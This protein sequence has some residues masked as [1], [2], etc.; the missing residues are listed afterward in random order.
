MVTMTN[1]DDPI[2]FDG[3]L[4]AFD[5]SDSIAVNLK[6]PHDA[7]RDTRVEQPS[8]SELVLLDPEGNQTSYKVSDYSIV[9]AIGGKYQIH[10][11]TYVDD[12]GNE[13]EFVLSTDPVPVVV[14][15]LVIACVAIIG[16]IA[17]AD[18]AAVLCKQQQADAIKACSAA[19]GLP[20]PKLSTQYAPKFDFEAKK[21]SIGCSVECSLECTRMP[22]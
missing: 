7:L 10:S 18:R 21:F 1:D 17:I 4:C 20:N 14:V 6:L 5:G 22:S 15:V 3:T 11:G 2:T 16:C 13:S 12:Q 8:D 19:G 9:R